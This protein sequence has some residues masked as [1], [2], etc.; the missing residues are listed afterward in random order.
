M[1]MVTKTKKFKE[2][3]NIFTTA[4][5]EPEP[6]LIQVAV[7][8]LLIDARLQHNFSQ[9]TAQIP[10]LIGTFHLRKKSMFMNF[11]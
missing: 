7:Q 8:Q 10:V 11:F 5:T 3:H 2:K 6:M 1:F 4:N 9:H